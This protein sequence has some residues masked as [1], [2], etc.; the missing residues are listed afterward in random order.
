[1]GGNIMPTFIDMFAGAGGFSEG[2]LQAENRGKVFEFLLASDINTTCEV[3]HRMR[4]NYQLGLQTEFL[5]K[6][7]TAP[8][9]IEDLLIKIKRKFGDVKIDVLTGGPPCQSFSL[10]GE[11]RKNDKK[12]DLFSYYLKVIE[13]VRPKYFVMENVSGILTKDNGKIKERIL[14]EIRN[15]VDYSALKDFVKLCENESVIK[16]IKVSNDI[17]EFSF[18]VRVLKIWIEQNMLL[19]NRRNDYQKVISSIKKLELSSI[20][21]EFV[22]KSI[23]DSKNEIYNSDLESF[24]VELSTMIVEAYRNNKET[25]EDERNVLRQVLSLIRHQ[26]DLYHVREMIKKE[27]N[28]SQLKRSIYKERFDCITDYLSMSEIIEI[29]ERQCDFLISRS[30]SARAIQATRSVKLALEILFE[31]VFETMQRVLRII[32]RTTPDNNQFDR[33][34]Q[35]VELYKI[36]APITLLAS[37]YGVPQNRVR[38][39]FIGC[40][41][42]QEM[43]TSIPATVQSGEKVTVK[44][45]IGDLEYIGVGEHAYDYSIKQRKVFEKEYYG[46]LKRTANS[47]PQERA[48]GKNCHTYSEWSRIGRLNPERFPQ[49]QVHLPTYTAANSYDEMRK[50][51]M[52]EAILQNHETSKHNRD[53]QARYGLIRKYGDYHKAKKAEPD[54]KLMKTKKRNYTVIIPNSQGT[55]ITTMPDDFIHYGANRSLTV[56]E[57]ARIQSFDDSFVFQGKRATGGDKRKIETPQFTQVGNAVPPLM[58]RAIA[59]EILKKIK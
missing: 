39:V 51:E 40:R 21:R 59:M 6:D 4:Y 38:V 2:F 33:I 8:D 54:N 9:F 13:A 25:P 57:M 30:S 1:M 48:Q 12:D 53:V 58:A 10:A 11:R 42:D 55:T 47:I 15:I 17:Q 29:A 7:I 22:L 27:I 50:C 36:E 28:A 32:K 23:L 20:Q 45:A 26:T 56:R 19:N 14:R 24:C 5:T 41:N 34:A 16:C 37:D 3:T 44:E 52:H 43:I 31:G 46:N 35:K 49:L 18:S